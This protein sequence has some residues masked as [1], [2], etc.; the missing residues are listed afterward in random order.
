MGIPHFVYYSSI[1]STVGCFYFIAIM[2]YAANEQMCG[3]LFSVLLGKYI[4][5]DFWVI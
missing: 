2:N 4:G 1:D 5:W 3:Y